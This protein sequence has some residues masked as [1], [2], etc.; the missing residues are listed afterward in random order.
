MIVVTGA[1]GYVGSRA[2]RRLAGLGLPVA[3]MGRNGARLRNAVPEGVPVLIADYDDR[4]SL[5]RAFAQVTK[6]LF[7][8]SDGFAEDM[9]RQHANV[10]DA[11]SRSAIAHVVFTGIVDIGEGSPFYFAPVYRDAERRLNSARFAVSIIRCGLYCDFILRHWLR[12]SV[13]SLPLSDARIAP[14]S[15]ADVAAAAVEAVLR[16][17]GG[18]WELTGAAPLSMADIAAAASR[19][20]GGPCAYRSCSPDD[21]RGRLE[22]GIEDPWPQAFSSLCASIREGRYAATSTEFAGIMSRPQEDFES[23]LRRCAPAGGPRWD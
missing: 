9:I 15:R 10:I 22:A 17:P 20:R 18:V 13:V 4:A 23:F 7:V 6:L 1:S 11:A 21:Y 8:A 12:D 2:V 5:D 3:A 16:E 14:I 19:V